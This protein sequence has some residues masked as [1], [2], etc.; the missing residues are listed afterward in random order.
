MDKV[1]SGSITLD[2]SSS[3]LYVEC[4]SEAFLYF[5]VSVI[6][7]PF[8]QYRIF[9]V[10]LSMIKFILVL[11]VCSFLTGEC[12]PPVQPPIVYNS[13]ADCATDASVKS[14]ELLQKEGKDNVNKYRLAVKFGCYPV[15]ET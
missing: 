4:D 8:T 11:S 7:F 13:W 6:F 9:N 10:G 14:L 1:T 2:K 15:S 12:K 5:V 3:F